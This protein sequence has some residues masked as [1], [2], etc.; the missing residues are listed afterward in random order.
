LT[1]RLLFGADPWYEAYANGLKA[2]NAGQWDAAEKHLK[3]AAAGGPAQGRQKRTYGTHFIAFL[4][5]YYLGVVYYYQKRYREAIDEFDR[6]EASGLVRK[7]DPEYPRLAD[8]LE[9]ARERM[10]RLER[11]R[12]A[13]RL[14]QAAA[15]PPSLP[16]TPAPAVATPAPTPEATAAPSPSPTP[17]PPTPVPIVPSSSTRPD[18][19]VKRV[20]GAVHRGDLPRARAALK[21]ARSSGIVDPAL[22]DL[23]RRLHELEKQFAQGL[24]ELQRLLDRHDLAAAL[25]KAADLA[26]RD[27]ADPELLRLQ[28]AL[29]RHLAT[30]GERERAG[31]LAFYGGRYESAIALLATPAAA[32]GAS[33][34]ALFYTACSHAAL[35]L[36][37]GAEA[38]GGTSLARAR[39]LFAQVRSSKHALPEKEWRLISPRIRRL[40]ESN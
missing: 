4:P 11:A 22:D 8:L 29:D 40:F 38:G 7:G 25:R 12:E 35:G 27:A 37:K 33:P 10:A 5:G 18:P 19:A 26:R 16:P 9:K 13:Q 21:A 30:P 34:R 24:A 23:E 17:V 2:I 32:P 28:V 6:V 36:L 31:V 3:V 14:A 1:A 39:S 20:E 15:I